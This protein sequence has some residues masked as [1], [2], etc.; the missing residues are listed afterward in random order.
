M[1]MDREIKWEDRLLRRERSYRSTHFGA[2]FLLIFIV[3]GG[4]FVVAAGESIADDSIVSPFVSMAVFLGMTIA[5][6]RAKLDHIATIRRYR[7][8]LVE[9]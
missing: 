1:E 7:A 4:A 5:Y 9:H 3:I 2:V 6:V 8:E